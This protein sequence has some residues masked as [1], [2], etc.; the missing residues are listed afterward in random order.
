[1]SPS[2]QSAQSS[3]ISLATLREMKAQG[4]KFSCLTAYDASFSR[5]L[6]AAGVEVLLVGDSLGMVIQGHE[7]TLPVS[8][9]EMIYHTACVSRVRRRALVMADMPFMSDRSPQQA[10]A[11]AARL[12]KEGG[13]HMVKIEG[14]AVMVETYRLLSSRGVPVCAHLGLLPQSVHKT[15]GYRLQGR[16]QSAAERILSDARQ[17]VA[18]GADAVLLECI[19]TSLA[20]QVVAAVNVPVIGIGAGA[21]CDG[22]VLVVYDMLGMTAGKLPRFCHNFLTAGGTIQEA[23]AA[24]VRAVKDGSFPDAAHAYR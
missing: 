14:G 9:E 22:Q 2:Q 20:D 3:L 16:C 8:L 24:Y 6:E 4:E 7:T 5:L 21:V 12:M 13:A 19:P 17:V 15:G 23:V 18:A 10:L 1:M 11:S